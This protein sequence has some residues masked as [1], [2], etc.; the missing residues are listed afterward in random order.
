M[1]NSDF[2]NILEAVLYCDDL[3]K[4][5]KWTIEIYYFEFFFSLKK[6][7]DMRKLFLGF[8]NILQEGLGYEVFGQ[9]RT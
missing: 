2:D 8:D 7:H 6:W 3:D 5:R 1:S 4:V 9:V